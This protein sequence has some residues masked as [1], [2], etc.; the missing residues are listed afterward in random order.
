[1]LRALDP[2]STIDTLRRPTRLAVPRARLTAAARCLVTVLL[3][4]LILRSIDIGAVLELIGRA[5]LPDLGWAAI[6]VAVQFVVLV[7]RWRLV[8][9]LLGG[10]PVGF[11]ALSE[12]LG[13]SS[14][15]GQVLPSSVGGDL[16]RI[17]MLARRT[18][19]AVAARSVVCDRL[20]GLAGLAL[21]VALTFPIIAVRMGGLASLPTLTIGVLGTAAA[22]VLIVAAP[23]FIRAVPSLRRPLA[24]LSGD[25]RLT[26]SFGKLS[27]L[28][29]GLG[30][31]SN[32]LTVL[33]IYVFGLAIGADLRAFDCLI[34]VPPAVL[35]SA[36]PISLA[37]WGV[38]E[39]ALLAAFS[40]VQADPAR[41]AA[42]S[43]MLGL[44]TPL[45]GAAV[46]AASLFAGWRNV[47]PKGSRDGR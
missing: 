24:T 36:L 47:L 34:L 43:V 33:L 44:N 13:H 31:G 16:A 18:G 30:V 45:A 35:A 42:T 40:L 39:G 20:I 37:G 32:L 7:W 15:I 38:R 8:I 3:V 11:R 4:G 22:A 2:V 12:L 9:R 5:A 29:V 14:L 6:V 26:L 46:A 10:E 1:M 21:L 25:L 17:V 41:V 23:L 19:T 27:L 28:A